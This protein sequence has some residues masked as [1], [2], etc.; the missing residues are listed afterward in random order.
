V[1]LEK[2]GGGRDAGQIRERLVKLLDQVKGP[3]RIEWV[4]HGLAKLESGKRR[5]PSIARQEFLELGQRRLSG[6]KDRLLHCLEISQGTGK[7]LFQRD[8]LE[9]V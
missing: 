1:V 9:A 7:P 4:T 5:Q 3:R 8:V 2:P 6:G